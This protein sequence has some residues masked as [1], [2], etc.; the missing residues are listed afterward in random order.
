MLKTKITLQDLLDVVSQTDIRTRAAFATALM[1]G[2]AAECGYDSYLLT[3]GRQGLLY[4]TG[5]EP[6]EYLEAIEREIS[7]AFGVVKRMEVDA[8]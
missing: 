5:D 6:A 2:I 3:N 7:D 8:I 1:S 4:V